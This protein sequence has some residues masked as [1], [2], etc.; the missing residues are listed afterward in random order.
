MLAATAAVILAAAPAPHRCA[1]D[2]VKKANALLR[3]HFSG[4]AGID[5]R[6]E[7]LSIDPVV[8]VLPSIAPIRG[9]GRYD[10][11]EVWG[12]IYKGEYRMRFI[13]ARIPDSCTLMGQEILESADVY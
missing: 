12:Y 5:R 7:N 1:A 6:I 8:K 4:N 13:Y 2:A 9:K 11:L 3:L 10:V